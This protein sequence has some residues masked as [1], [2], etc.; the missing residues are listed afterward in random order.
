MHFLSWKMMHSLVTY[1]PY[2]AIFVVISF[3][4]CIV[5][6]EWK[7]RWEWQAVDD[8][9]HG[10]MSICSYLSLVGA[11][12]CS[13]T[14]DAVPEGDLTETDTGRTAKELHAS[15]LSSHGVINFRWPSRWMRSHSDDHHRRHCAAVPARFEP[16]SMK[17]NASPLYQQFLH[18]CSDI[19][20]TLKA[21][22]RTKGATIKGRTLTPELNLLKHFCHWPLCTSRKA[23]KN[24]NLNEL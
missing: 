21:N 7:S 12:L 19:N 11:Y 15:L 13:P 4:W 6:I 1:F 3:V 2:S 22:R 9:R 18:C 8:K 5:L 17:P 14:G 16:V 24:D 23:L 20:T 10:R